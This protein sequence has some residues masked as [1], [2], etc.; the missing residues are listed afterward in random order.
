MTHR[1]RLAAAWDHREPDRIPVSLGVQQEVVNFRDGD[2][3]LRLAGE[4]DNFSDKWGVITQ[5]FMGVKS[6]YAEEVIEDRPGEFRKIRRIQK[7]PA[8]DFT[9]IT[10]HPA[11]STDYHWEK[12]Y[13][14]TLDDL[15]RLAEAPREPLAWFKDKWVEHLAACGE[16]AYPLCACPH[17]LGALVRNS[18][19]EEMYGWFVSESELVHRFLAVAN[20]QVETVIRGMS[21]D[22]IQADYMTYALEMLIPPWM[23]RRLFDEFVAPYD[24][25]V[26]AAIHAGGGRMRAHCHGNCGSLLE[27]IA[28]MGVDAAEPLEKPPRGDVD[29][30]WAKRTVG[31]RMLL[32][33]NIASES[34]NTMHPDEVRKE[35]RLAIATAGKGGGFTLGTSGASTTLELAQTKEEGDRMVANYIAYIEAG[36]EG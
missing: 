14:A 1:E 16:R 2:K 15:R 17:P 12:R 33:G 25:A 23:G 4:L 31:H 36:L 20:G 35:V 8:G 32:T 26:N 7:T 30:A 22:G 27:A 18:T 24:G 3:L 21:A 28:D 19:M 5:G 13:I 34:F 29:L 10:W 11:D 6:E 9:A